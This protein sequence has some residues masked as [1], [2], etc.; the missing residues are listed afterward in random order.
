MRG[1]S[2]S[3]RTRCRGKK[4]FHDLKQAK[5]AIKYL[6]A[7]STRE[8]VPTRAFE[9]VDCRGVHL[10]SSPNRTDSGEPQ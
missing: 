10:T 9:C 8:R 3:D 2:H 6:N 5:N 1:K 4:R 7:T